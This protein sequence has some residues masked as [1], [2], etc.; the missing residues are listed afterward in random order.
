MP[1]Q[2]GPTKPQVPETE[3]PATPQQMPLAKVPE[4]NRG[5]DYRGFISSATAGHPTTSRGPELHQAP[6]IAWERAESPEAVR[7][8]KG[9]QPGTVQ[10]LMI[11]TSALIAAAMLQTLISSSMAP[12][13][14]SSHSDPTRSSAS[15]ERVR[16]SPKPP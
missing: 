16:P 15:S 7:F 4:P 6:S 3:Q 8:S 11:L 13:P 5:G 10:R 1:F 2:F 12:I 9:M 14:T